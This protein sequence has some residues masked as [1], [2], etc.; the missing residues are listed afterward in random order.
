MVIGIDLGTTFSVAA[1]VDKNGEP[2]IIPNL[3]GTDTTPSVVMFEG[4][5]VTIGQQAKLNLKNDPYNV[6]QLAKTKIGT[7][8]PVL[9]R[10]N[11]E[12]YFAE[13][14][15]ARILLAIKSYCED[16]LGEKVNACVITV[17]A[18]F[19]DAQKKATLDAAK[20]AELEVLGLIN[21]PTA[22]ILYYCH[23]RDSEKNTV[24]IYDLGGGTFDITIAN[25]HNGKVEV[26]ATYGSRELGGVHFENA[27]MNYVSDKF[28]KETGKDIFEDDEA[29]QELRSACEQ[30]KI[31]LSARDKFSIPVKMQG[32]KI[33]VEVT[34]ELFETLIKELLHKTELGIQIALR[35]FSEKGG[36]PQDIDKILLVGGSTKI[37]AVSELI[38]RV[39][40]IEPSK[41]VNPDL[42]VALGAAIYANELAKISVNIAS[43]DLDTPSQDVKPLL[44]DVTSH[45]LGTSA[46]NTYGK[47][48]N[49]IVITANEPVPCKRRRVYSVKANQSN[50][51][52]DINE[53]DD[54]DL[55]YVTKIGDSE[56]PIKPRL[57]D[58]YIGIEMGYDLNALIV[59]YAFDLFGIDDVAW[60]NDYSIIVPTLGEV[61]IQRDANLTEEQIEYKKQ[62][63]SKEN[64]Q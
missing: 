32:S 2:K 63:L 43:N 59:C 42:V 38:K 61:K 29:V 4:D 33:K 9:M 35:A 58:Y 47:R 48:I 19:T 5:E 40:K 24:M 39:L 34:R 62:R 55:S 52:L 15:S 18:Y 11:G 45:G 22:A 53:G 36:T 51:L 10:D 30:A 26:V 49:D 28:K 60:E 6:A 54:D 25:S 8:E 46:V 27:L 31:A 20:I 50:I 1:Y 44:R 13:E 16:R 57:E 64:I 56:I 17:P 14:I 7:K 23:D 3:D 21:E 41:E 37:P 12:Q